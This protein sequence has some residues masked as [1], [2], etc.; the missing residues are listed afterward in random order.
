MRSS[1]GLRALGGYLFLPRLFPRLG[2]LA[3]DTGYFAQLMALVF[4][5]IGLLPQGHRLLLGANQGK[6]GIR[7][8]M[9]EAA[10]NLKGGWRHTDHY[11][12]YA[13]FL[14]GIVLFLL[15]FGVLVF[16][17]LTHS[18][19]AAVPFIS[20]FV[21]SAP[22]NDVA[23]MMLDKIFQ[24]PGFFGSSFDPV[25][26]NGIEALARGTQELF[27]F[28]SMGMLSVAFFIILYYVFVVTVETAQTGVP[29]GKRFPSIYGPIRLVLCILLLLPLAYG[30]NTGQYMVLWMAK[31]GSSFATNAWISYN[32]VVDSYGGT[33]PM[34]L[35]PEELIGQPKVQPIDGLINFFYVAHTCKA[36]YKIAYGG[37]KQDIEP[38]LV[39]PG[40]ATNGATATKMTSATSFSDTLQDFGGGDIVVTFGEKDDKYTH[41]NGGVKPYCGRIVIPVDSKDVSKVTAIYDAYFNYIV[42]LWNNDDLKAY[43]NNMAYILRF[44]DKKQAGGFQTPSVDWDAP[45]TDSEYAPAGIGFYRDMRTNLQAQF[46]GDIQAAIDDMRQNNITEM[47]MSDEI[48]ELGWGGAGIWYNRIA[49]FNGA[50]VDAVFMVPTPQAYPLVMEHVAGLKKGL[51]SASNPKT[52]FSPTTVTGKNVTMEKFS[53]GADLDNPALDI[54]IANLL[55]N[56]YETVADDNVTGR[57]KPPTVANDPVRNVFM[58]IYEE[59]GLM[60]LRGN[61]GVYPLAKL[62]MLGKTI[63]DKTIFSLSVGSVMSGFG[64]LLS[65]SG[66]KE[67][68]AAFEQGGGVLL[69]FATTGLVIGFV[70]YYLIPFFPFIYFFFAVGRWVK[71]IFE[72]MVGVP[73]WALA[74]LRLDGEGVGNA[75]SKGYFLL[76]EIMLRPV[77]TVFGLL[78]SVSIFAALSSVLDSVFDLVVW[79]VAGYDMTTLSSGSPTPAGDFLSSFRDVADAFFYTILY[80]IILYMMAMASFKLVDLIPNK[81]MRFLQP[82]PTFRDGSG[83][84]AQNLVRNTAYSGYKL[85]AELGKG[86]GDFSSG[87]G[88]SV[89]KVIGK[90]MD[91]KMSGPGG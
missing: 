66:A 16:L 36:A 11:I 63:I 52:R 40:N 24:I 19:Q 41:Y 35:E 8:V 58:Y 67:L 49:E 59:S 10:A 33:N 30:Y 20:M 55:S 7:A 82:V 27:R 83:D 14:L 3:P 38:Y 29:F 68:G 13:A 45:L 48:L 75:A 54:E 17:L 12:V 62:S 73:L 15:Q 88:T 28:Y 89:G 57:P 50:A 70:L 53:S 80:A 76:L 65:G 43:G 64:G 87:V 91:D 60:D 51:E 74:H 32:T 86:L 56:V 1:E 18:A 39:V 42:T 26:D 37:Q 46:N 69:G 81:V 23:F 79:N 61:D 44:M 25:S 5:N 78:A 72:A 47:E 22:E 9:A 31:W 84:P 34:G 21:T 85:T 90:G 77:F 2:E 71:S 4:G 6:Y